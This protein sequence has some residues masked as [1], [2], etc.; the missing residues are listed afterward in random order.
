MSSNTSNEEQRQNK[1]EKTVKRGSKKLAM[2]PSAIFPSLSP[3]FETGSS[4]NVQHMGV[5]N[6]GND[7]EN[8]NNKMA[9]NAS[10]LR[11]ARPFHSKA[12][13]QPT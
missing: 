5:S 8:T 11:N 1:K 9:S 10:Q 7:D 2:A 3:L 4:S 6:K 12:P 13:P